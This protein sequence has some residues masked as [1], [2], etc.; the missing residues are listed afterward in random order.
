MG[1]RFFQAEKLRDIRELVSRANRLYSDKIAFKELG[2][3]KQVYEYS[4]RRLYEDMNSFGTKLLEMGLKGSHIA[5]IGENS[6]SWV[7]SYLTIVNGLGVVVPLDKELIDGDIAKLIRD[8]DASAVICSNTFAAVIKDISEQCPNLKTCIV[9]NPRKEY[10]GFYTI[11]SLIEEGKELIRAGNKDY[12]QAEID[13]EAMCE[14]VFTSGTTGAN[15]GVMLSQKNLTA[16]VYGS[17]AVINSSGESFSVL[18]INHTYECSCHILGSIYLGQTVCFNDSLKRVSENMKFFKPNFSIM[19]PLFL[20]AM[21]KSIWKEAEKSRLTAHLKYGL[22]FSNIIRKFGIDKRTFFFKP[23]LQ[24]FGGNLNQI[25]CGGAPLRE[26]IIKTLSDFGIEILNG[27]G[28]TECAPLVA[29]N[30]ILWKKPGSV[31]RIVPCC[32]VRIHDTEEKGYGEI[33]VKG[34]NVMMGYYKD[35]D[36]T[37]R[38]FTEDGWFKTGDIGYLDK[39]NFLYINGRVKNLIILPNGKNVH[40][41]ELEDI[42]IEKLAY[43]K[44]VVVYASSA[45]GGS[46]DGINA[47]VCID[48]DFC[49]TNGIKDPINK[50]NED[51]KSMNRHLPIYKRITNVLISES[52]FEKTTTK[53]IKRNVVL[54][55]SY[56]SV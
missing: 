52:E 47:L 6:Y 31:G 54:G 46:E 22:K 34:D 28:I 55:R 50:L 16:V 17:M 41:E 33:L 26:E 42:I 36:S 1:R 29:A 32:Q 19:V 23:I 40:P 44:E 7:V 13:V 24:G 20:E 37:L 4:F 39:D 48:E 14:I 18:P 12:L 53:K 5:V 8:S 3:K 9:M 51:I 38:S 21:Y 25:V 30:S 45:E 11:E 43:V 35:E 49:E 2:A 10:E 27:Y 56:E 15:K